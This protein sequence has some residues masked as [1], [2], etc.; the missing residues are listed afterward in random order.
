[1]NLTR[2]Y[3][4][5][6]G[7]CIRQINDE[8]K[9]VYLT[10]D[11]GP[12][13]YFTPIVLQLLLKLEVKATFFLIGEN[14]QENPHIVEQIIKNGHTIGNHSLD[15]NTSHYFHQQKHLINWLESSNSLFKKLKIESI[16]FRSPLGMKTPPLQKALKELEMILVLW[17]IR[18]YD[19]NNMLDK[20]RIKKS[21]NKIKKGSIILLHDT[22]K[23]EFRSSFLEALEY[24]IFEIKSKGLSFKALNK[25]II[26][27]SFKGKYE[28]EK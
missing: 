16:G 12:D 22:Q 5:F 20:K 10:F 21:L 27:E 8:N 26:N 6:T 1:M 24:L 17:N 28:I 15:H 4:F 9:S 25:R 19:T 11:D 18:Y 13:P 14:A 3:D 7:P 2:M 23:E